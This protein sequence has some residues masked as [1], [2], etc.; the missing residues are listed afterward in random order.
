MTD[1][2]PD[3]PYN[4]LAKLPPNEL[5]EDPAILKKVNKAKPKKRYIILSLS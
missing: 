4:K 1:F 5:F 3:I 2:F